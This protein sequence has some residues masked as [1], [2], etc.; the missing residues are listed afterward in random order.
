MRLIITGGTGLIGRALA[1]DLAGDS[2]EVIV[3]SRAPERATAIPAGVRVERWDARTAEGWGALADGADAIVNL[4][5]ESIAGKGL[6]PSRWTAE[7]KSRIRDSRLNAGRAVV[8][9]VELARDK[10]RVVVQASGVG[11]Y[12]PRGD[13]ELA[14]EASPGQ[15][16]LA[17]TAIEW[18]ASTAPV[19]SLGVR[20]AIIR[21][22]AV[23]SI[24][25][26]AF[27][28]MLLPFQLL[29]GGALGSGRQWLPWIHIADEVRAIRFLIENDAAGGPLNLVAPDLL[30]NA[31]FCQVLGQVMRRPA[32]IRVPAFAL[33]LLLGEMS[34]VLLEG[35][36]AIPRR[37]QDLG[38]TF[39]FPDAEAAL[40]DLLR[41]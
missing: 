14:E 37:L 7:R 36:K 3:L 28:F 29:V 10:P 11:Y 18:E 1:A 22:G 32:F 9:A 15:D 35:Q 41:K 20:R 19:E 13:E 4:A 23:L 30:T 27:P 26:G 8:Q 38:F 25:G 21:S 24:K 33:R 40:R 17:R 12:G 34:I 16:F 39:R 31:E 5:G 2:H 6:I